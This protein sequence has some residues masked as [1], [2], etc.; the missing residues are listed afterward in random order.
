MK[1]V[2]LYGIMRI[3]FNR[4]FGGI[5]VS[6]KYGVYWKIGK[7]LWRALCKFIY[8]FGIKDLVFTMTVYIGYIFVKKQWVYL[9]VTDT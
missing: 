4:A 1:V 6:F 2:R 7:I 8:E 9:L 5:R 3:I